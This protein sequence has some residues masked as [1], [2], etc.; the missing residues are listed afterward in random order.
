MSGPFANAT[1]IEPGDRPGSYRARVA[2]GWDI[3]GNANGGYLLALA[4]RALVA[5]T[6]RPCPAS[7]TAHYLSPGKPGPLEIETTVIREGRR[8]ATASA[9]MSAGGRPVLAVLGTFGDGPSDE[10]AESSDDG[11]PSGA[12]GSPRWVNATPPDLPPP[13]ECVGGDDRVGEPPSFATHVDQRLHPG[14]VGFFR[15]EP[16]GQARMRGWFRFPEGEQVDAIGLTCAI[17]AFP[18]TIFNLDLPVGWTPTLELTVH[19]RR[20]PAPGWLACVFTTRFVT[21]GVLEEDGE[22]WDSEGHLVAQG[23]Q[24]ALVP[25]PTGAVPSG[26]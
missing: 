19:V 3:G 25:R 1:A 4:A 2:E 7:L 14:D 20:Q 26:L 21:D 8:F 11:R 9:T 12:V 24:L 16:S 22:I 10:R 18:P 5:A 17:D 15:G 23:R 6:G 13:E